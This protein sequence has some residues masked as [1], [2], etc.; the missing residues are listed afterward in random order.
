MKKLSSIFFLFSS[1]LCISF[2]SHP[3]PFVFFL[4]FLFKKRR[5]FNLTTKLFILVCLTLFFSMYIFLYIRKRENSEKPNLSMFCR[6]HT[7]NLSLSYFLLM[8][9]VIIFF[10]FFFFFLN[11]FFYFARKIIQLNK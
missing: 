2:S 10:P 4:F 3:L 11:F 1:R 7:Q 5:W 8:L 6:I 9:L